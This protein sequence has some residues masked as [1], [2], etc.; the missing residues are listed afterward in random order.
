MFHDGANYFQ[1]R[2][3]TAIVMEVPAQSIGDPAATVRAWITVSLCGHAPEVQ[4]SRWGLPLLTV[5]Q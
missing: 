2:N 4:V 5:A 1:N 3:V